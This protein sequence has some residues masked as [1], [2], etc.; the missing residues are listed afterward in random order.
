MRI[1]A[2]ENGARVTVC[3]LL[4]GTALAATVDERAWRGA[5]ESVRSTLVDASPGA[6]T[7]LHRAVHPASD[8]RMGELWTVSR[9]LIMPVAGVTP[10]DLVDTFMQVRGPERRHEAIDIPAPRGTPVVAV[11][12][13][14]VVRMTDHDSGGITLY[15][16]A[17]DGQTLFYYAHLL[18]YAD[19]LRPGL[20]VRQG[21]VLGYVGDTGNAA[22]GSYHLHFEV[23]TA[24]NA[25][26]Y[27]ALRP[28][29]PYPLLIRARG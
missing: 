23:M 13:G 22:P 27:H 26:Q 1:S 15:L 18:G 6:Q 11:T 14:E 4:L 25:R 12:A 2:A 16:L 29:N 17:P 7:R 10:D 24:S 5:D 28:R 9:N 19:G 8:P 21:D 3:V 20:R